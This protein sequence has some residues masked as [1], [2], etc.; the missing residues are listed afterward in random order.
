MRP[1]SRGILVA[2][3]HGV[4]PVGGAPAKLAVP[5]VQ[6]GVEDVRVGGAV[7]GE[8]AHQV[9]VGPEEGG[10]RAVR[11]SVEVPVGRGGIADQPWVFDRGLDVAVVFDSVHLRV[12][13]SS[14]W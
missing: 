4:E 12:F 8:G 9:A 5:D 1:V 11:D 6:T 10:L 3:T 13:V 14:E 7:P 2:P